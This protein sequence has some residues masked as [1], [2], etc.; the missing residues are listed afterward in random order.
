MYE[1]APSTA[2]PAEALFADLSPFCLIYAHIQ[3][4]KRVRYIECEHLF[5]TLCYRAGDENNSVMIKMIGAH[6]FPRYDG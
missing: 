6:C 5:P 2:N 4:S 3:G 1:Y